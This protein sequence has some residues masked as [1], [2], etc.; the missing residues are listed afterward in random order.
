[1]SEEDDRRMRRVG[2]W[3]AEQFGN[4]PFFVGVQ[5]AAGGPLSISSLCTDDQIRLLAAIQK[6]LEGPTA[7]K[8]I[9]GEPAPLASSFDVSPWD[10][11][12]AIF[13]LTSLSEHWQPE[14][15]AERARVAR[16]CKW[17]EAWIAMAEAE[18]GA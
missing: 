5:P 4:V 15:I 16:V 11:R 2:M 7:Q 10:V 3:L 9:D 8:F 1:M 6:S 18:Q 12:Q 17:L 13:L 14:L